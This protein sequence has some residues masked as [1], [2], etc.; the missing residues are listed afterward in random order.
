MPRAYS[1]TDLIIGER[2]IGKNR[3]ISL[4]RRESLS[5][6]S[7]DDAHQASEEPTR[8]LQK[9]NVYDTFTTHKLLKCH[10]MYCHSNSVKNTLDIG[11]DI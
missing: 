9:H 11:T 6:I 1:E 8:P 3:S 4:C 7:S 2:K 10:E 5:L